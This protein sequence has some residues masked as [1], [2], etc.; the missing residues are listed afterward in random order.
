MEHM[1]S[2]VETSIRMQPLNSLA[3]NEPSKFRSKN[4]GPRNHLSYAHRCRGRLPCT[5]MNPCTATACNTVV[6]WSS[7]LRVLT[8]SPLC[9]TVTTET[10]IETKAFE[11]QCLS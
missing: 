5:R 2:N 10:Q 9:R 8:N 3:L 11:R 4:S 6:A 1:Y 7:Y